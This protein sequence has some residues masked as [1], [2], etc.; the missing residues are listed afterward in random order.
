MDDAGVHQQSAAKVLIVAA[1]PSKFQV[2][3]VALTTAAYHFRS[4]GPV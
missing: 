3:K 4:E 1:D 2:L